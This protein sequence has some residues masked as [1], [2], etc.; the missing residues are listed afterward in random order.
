MS[1]LLGLGQG[2]IFTIGSVVFIGVF[3]AAINLAYARFNE[4]GDDDGAG[5]GSRAGRTRL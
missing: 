2:V 1:P 3:T 4:L 5:R